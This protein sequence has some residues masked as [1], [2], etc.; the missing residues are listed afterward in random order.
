MNKSTILKE[1]GIS[2]W[3]LK[4][5]DRYRDTKSD[6]KTIAT[7]QEQSSMQANFP[8]W[9]VV[10]E[11]TT[12]T[13][14]LWENVRKVIKNFGVELQIITDPAQSI[15]AN[16]IQ[17]SLLIALGETACQ[18]FSGERAPISEL[19][20]ILFETTN[21]YDQEIPVIISYSILDLLRDPAKKKQFWSD[22]I[23]ARNVFLDTMA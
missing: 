7:P 22:L 10:L 15:S 18:H 23:F 4:D 6:T 21:Q 16:Q 8:I 19:R 3:R 13:K 9:T 5:V 20:E 11:D 14:S 17:G 1:M 12:Q 2:S